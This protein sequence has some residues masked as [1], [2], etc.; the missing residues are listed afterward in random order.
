VVTLAGLLLGLAAGAPFGMLGVAIGVAAT[1]LLL[2]YPTLA[3]GVRGSALRA[4]DALSVLWR[5]LFA[6]AAGI[7]AARAAGALIALPGPGLVALVAK[8]A[9]FGIAYL[10]SWALLPGGGALIRVVV[11]LAQDLIGARLTAVRRWRVEP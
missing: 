5:S 3:Y 1:R 4:A 11:N 10:F 7:A 8:L 2:F 6:C 9:A